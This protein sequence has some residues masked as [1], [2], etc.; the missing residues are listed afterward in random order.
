LSFRF[1]FTLIDKDESCDMNPALKKFS[2]LSSK[3]YDL[4]FLFQFKHRLNLLAHHWDCCQCIKGWMQGVK[5]RTHRL[6]FVIL[7]KPI[8]IYVT[9]M[10]HKLYQIEKWWEWCEILTK[11]IWLFF[12]LLSKKKS[13]I[14]KYC[15]KDKLLQSLFLCFSIDLNKI[16]YS[17]IYK[18]IWSNNLVFF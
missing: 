13:I 10:H 6:I 4:W 15:Y 2:K 3:I 7:S 5:G 12:L 8:L 14:L 9:I 16:S 1:I 17:N 11:L 18:T